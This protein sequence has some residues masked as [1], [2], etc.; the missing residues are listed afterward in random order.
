MEWLNYFLLLGINCLF[1]WK[2]SKYMKERYI[3]LDGEN[4]WT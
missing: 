3:Y 1:Q 2:Q 4:D